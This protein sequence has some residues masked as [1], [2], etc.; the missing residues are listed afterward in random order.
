M[1]WSVQEWEEIDIEI[2]PSKDK[3]P[4]YTNL[5]YKNRA[6]DGD[7]ILDFDPGTDWHDYEIIWKPDFIAWYL[8]GREVMRKTDSRESVRDMDKFSLLYMNFWTP[9][10][11][12]WGGGRDDSTMPWYTS[13]DYVEAY[14]WD[15]ATDSFTLR[16]RDD[17]DTLDR[18]IWRVSDNWGFPDNSSKFMDTHTYVKD[19]KLILKLDHTLNPPQPNPPRPDPSPGPEPTPNPDP[20]TPE[21]C[22][23]VPDIKPDAAA[24]RYGDKCESKHNRTTCG[25][26]YENCH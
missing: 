17:F 24:Y 11:N 5:I 7:Y 20:P 23:D 6:M 9:T 15:A 10:W 22:P 13:Y 1:E 26:D 21:P 19:G 8:D 14:D 25:D 2:V 12:D 3:N 16:F 18:N 4:F